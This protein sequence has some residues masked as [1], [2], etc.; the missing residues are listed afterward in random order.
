MKLLPDGERV[1]IDFEGTV[2][3]CTALPSNKAFCL[4]D[5]FN[6]S[7]VSVVKNGSFLF[8]TNKMGE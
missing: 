2:I 5:L 8:Y 4:N 7:V 3:D 1:I 6:E